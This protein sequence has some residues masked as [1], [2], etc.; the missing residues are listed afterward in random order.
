MAQ[1]SEPHHKVFKGFGK[2]QDPKI[3]LFHGLIL[4]QTELTSLLRNST[5][6]LPKN[7]WNKKLATLWL[8]EE[9]MLA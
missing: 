2:N 5:A 6:I 4:F 3:N 8:Q 1:Y 9:E 7:N